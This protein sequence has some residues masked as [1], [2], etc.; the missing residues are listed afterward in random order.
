MDKFSESLVTLL[1]DEEPMVAV[2]AMN[3][4][5]KKEDALKE[6]L[7]IY[8]DSTDALV[9]KRIHQVS[10]VLSIR[11]K[12]QSFIKSIKSG[13]GSLINQLVQLAAFENP[14]VSETQ[15]RLGFSKLV[16]KLSLMIKDRPLTTDLMV[17]FM[18]SEHFFVPELELL[19][20]RLYMLDTVL[21]VKLGSAVLLTC[22]AGALGTIFNWQVKFVIHAGDFCLL[23]DQLQL[24]NANLSWKVTKLQDINSCFPCQ[25][26]QL[27]YNIVSVLFLIALQDGEL[28][29]IHLYG[30]LLTEICGIDF[31]ELP[32]P[33]GTSK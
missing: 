14:K 9:R 3:E 2:Q 10:T 25:P 30:D 16:K 12:K 24:V 28:K 5:L 13:D 27:V 23:D 22:L 18:R 4:M 29:L 31:S 19:E 32:F 7:S 1:F 21:E 17:N 6:I 11:H 15:I 33:V 8:Q 20:G 26:N